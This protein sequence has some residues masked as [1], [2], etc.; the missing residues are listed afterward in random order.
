VRSTSAWSRRAACAA[1]RSRCRRSAS[2]DLEQRD[3]EL[4]PSTV[5]SLTPT[6]TRS[7]LDLQLLAHRRAG[8]LALEVAHLD[9][10]HDAAEPVDLRE[11][12]LRLRFQPVGQRLDVVG[13]GER[14][15]GVGHPGL[16]GED[17]LRAQRDLHRLLGRERER[18][19]HGVG[20]QRLRAAEHRRERLVGDADDVVLRL[21]RGQRHAGRLRVG[22]EPPALGVLRAVP[23]AQRARPD[24]ARGAEL[25]DLLE[26]VVV[27]VPE[28]GEAGREVVHV[29]P[30]LDAALHVLEAVAQ[31]VGEL[32]R[33]RRARLA[34]VVAG[35][36][37][38]VV[39]RRVRAH[40]SNMS[41]TSLSAGSGG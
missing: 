4:S 35:D 34:D 28:E 10:R 5:N 11:D 21:L 19:V 17:L 9:P 14:V 16:E 29:E 20:V 30:A 1:I 23:V 36:R 3:L 24:P 26:E 37:D 2:S 32:L 13:A 40:H 22:A 33:R 41:T 7:P 12:L 31:R 15:D 38:R 27:H 6:M 18:L 25:R 8:D 39:L